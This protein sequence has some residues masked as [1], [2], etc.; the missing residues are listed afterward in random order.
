MQGDLAPRYKGLLKPTELTVKE[1][2]E[3]EQ[4]LDA[5]SVAGQGVLPGQVLE[6]GVHLLVQVLPQ[7]EGPESNKERLDLTP[8][9]LSISSRFPTHTATNFWLYL[10]LNFK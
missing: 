10:N 9:L 2:L 7:E 5:V 1:I 3:P 4:A 6:L 8:V